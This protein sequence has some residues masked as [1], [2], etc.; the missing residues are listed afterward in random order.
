MLLRTLAFL[1][2]LSLASPAM[3]DEIVFSNFGPGMTFDANG[4]SAISGSIFGFAQQ[5]VSEQFT[6][7][8]DYTF[9]DAQVAVSLYSGSDSFNVFLQADSSGLPGAVIEEI[10]ISGLGQTPAILT[11][12]SAL[13]PT[14]QSGT[15]YWLTLMPGAD[16]VV[17]GWHA[18]SIGDNASEDTFAVTHSGSVTGPWYK[19]FL[20]LTRDAFEI[21]GTPVSTVPEPSSLFMLV[22]GLTVL[23]YF[24]WR[25][26]PRIADHEDSQP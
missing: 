13:F 5:S 17:G 24:A 8:E 26:R 25:R 10:S 23:S 12:N 14:L 18:N 4:G 9:T 21:D 7:A 2:A 6:P 22:C 1:A 20:S 16:D 11:A 19:G 3:A 15:P